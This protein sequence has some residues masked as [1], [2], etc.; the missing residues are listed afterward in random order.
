LP[1]VSD[2]GLKRSA[3][4]AKPKPNCPLLLEPSRLPFL[5]ISLSESEVP[6][7]LKMAPVA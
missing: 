1:E 4:A 3:S 2:V 5:P 6:V 7:R